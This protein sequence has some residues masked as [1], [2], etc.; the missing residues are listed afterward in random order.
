MTVFTEGP[1][2][3][4]FIISEAPGHLSRDAATIDAS[5][6]ALLPGQVLGTRS[7]GAAAGAANGGNTGN[8]TISAITL[9][10]GAR[11]GAYRVVFTA[12]TAYD[13]IDPDGRKLASGATGAAY[14]GDLGFTITVGGTPMVAGDGF[15]ITVGEG[16]GAYV[17]LSEDATDGSQVASAILFEG[18]GEEIARRTIFARSGEV[19]SSKLAWFEDATPDQIAAGIAALADHGIVVR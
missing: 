1:R 2:T 9:R 6:G 7:L 4:E 19:K 18:I 15:T 3:A 11:S 8:A 16:D 13:V 5:E 10:D 12:A 14:A 17:A